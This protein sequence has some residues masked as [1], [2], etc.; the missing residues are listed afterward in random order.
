M[1]LRVQRGNKL[2][3]VRMALGKQAEI[4]K[5]KAKITQKLRFYSRYSLIFEVQ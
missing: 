5:K 2:T 1:G 4:E 3:I